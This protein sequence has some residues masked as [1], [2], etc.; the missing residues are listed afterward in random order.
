[1]LTIHNNVGANKDL[2]QTSH[3]HKNDKNENYEFA[4]T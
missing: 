1:M 3:Q 4:T 2:T